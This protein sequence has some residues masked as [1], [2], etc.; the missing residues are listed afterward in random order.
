[1]TFHAEPQDYTHYVPPSAI[2]TRYYALSNPYA[3]PAEQPTHSAMHAGNPLPAEAAP[4]GAPATGPPAVTAEGAPQTSFTTST[5]PARVDPVL[6]KQ[7]RNRDDPG[8]ESRPLAQP[9]SLH[10][11]GPALLRLGQNPKVNVACSYPQEFQPGRW[12]PAA[13]AAAFGAPAGGAGFHYARAQTPPAIVPSQWKLGA[14]LDEL[15]FSNRVNDRRTTAMAASSSQPYPPTRPGPS[16]PLS[17]EDAARL[18]A[19]K[20]QLGLHDGAERAGPSTS[21]A[22]NPSPSAST[23]GTD[24]EGEYVMNKSAIYSPTTGRKLALS[25]EPGGKASVQIVPG[26]TS[27]KRPY[28]RGTP[29]A[30]AFCRK[31][32]IACGGPQEGDEARR[33]G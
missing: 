5:S 18:A 7:R 13:A 1:M 21:A 12:G 30:C 16:S 29:V 10:E 19:L 20:M 33:C 32:K 27:A 15:R 2:S 4:S 9:A 11:V 8:G 25:A 26:T 6:P 22:A 28:K 31:R 14:A 17:R 3:Y 23:P 24:S